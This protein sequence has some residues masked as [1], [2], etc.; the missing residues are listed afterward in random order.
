MASAAASMDM[1]LSIPAPLSSSSG[2]PRTERPTVQPVEAAA[3]AATAHAA[4]AARCALFRR[5]ESNRDQSRKRTGIM[6]CG[7]SH[8]EN[9]LR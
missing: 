7:L 5:E 1:A 2:P 3:I 9:Q 8:A 6:A 4:N